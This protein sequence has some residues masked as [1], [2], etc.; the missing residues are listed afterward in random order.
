[1]ATDYDQERFIS[2][3]AKFL[4]LPP[5][6]CTREWVAATLINECTNFQ[7]AVALVFGLS[8]ATHKEY[9]LGVVE[10]WKQNFDKDCV[11]TDQYCIQFRDYYIN[12]VVAYPA[13][14]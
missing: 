6:K 10:H 12:E 5:E 2:D 9:I 4:K 7:T 3:W 11:A 13:D 8:V 14:G 1:M